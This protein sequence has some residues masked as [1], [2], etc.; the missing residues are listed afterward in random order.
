MKNQRRPWVILSA[1][2]KLRKQA[3]R[4]RYAEAGIWEDNKYSFHGRL[5]SATPAGAAVRGV[6]DP[7]PVPEQI[8]QARE[9]PWGIVD[10]PLIHSV[11]LRPPDR[12]WL[13][14]IPAGRLAQS[15]RPASC[16]G[17]LGI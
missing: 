12:R 4:S 8:C 3:G 15:D 10:T 6:P 16:S 7:S 5:N 11:S 9:P 14:T 1:T 2:N 13:S 17:L